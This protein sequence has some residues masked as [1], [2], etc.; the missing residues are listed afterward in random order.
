MAMP[1]RTL[2]RLGRL[3][4]ARERPEGAEEDT[5]IA[6]ET[7]DLDPDEHWVT[8]LEAIGPHPGSVGCSVSAGASTNFGRQKLEVVAWGTVPCAPTAEGMREGYARV[9]SF[10]LAAVETSLDEA[11][12]RF[13]PDLWGNPPEES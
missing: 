10:L 5:V 11:G 1:R 9:K 3:L 4:R 7:E 12:N 6:Q 2:P 8:D 13:F